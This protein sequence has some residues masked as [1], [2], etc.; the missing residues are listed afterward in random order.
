MS[1]Q[2]GSSLS[3]EGHSMLEDD[4]MSVANTMKTTDSEK[5]R[6]RYREKC[7]EILARLYPDSSAGAI[8]DWTPQDVLELTAL[9]GLAR[10]CRQAET[11]KRL[12]ERSTILRTIHKLCTVKP[13]NDLADDTLFR[14]ERHLQFLAVA[15]RLYK[16]DGAILDPNL[17]ADIYNGVNVLNDTFQRARKN[18]PAAREVDQWNVLFLIQHCQYLLISI[19]DLD[20]LSKTVAKRVFKVMDGAL[21]GYGGQYVDA[22][23]TLKEIVSRQRSRPRWHE[24]YLGMDDL[25]AAVS[26]RGAV[27]E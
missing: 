17:N 13:F 6:R 25:V 19:G 20:S 15:L 22:R 7:F 14:M 23:N 11:E 24:E 21:Q 2:N 26:A 27:P 5:T 16:F 12:L 4:D 8:P 1:S 3:A 9:F 10:V 18:C